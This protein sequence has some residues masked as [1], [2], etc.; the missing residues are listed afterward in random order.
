M[1]SKCSFLKIA[2]KDILTVILIIVGDFSLNGKELMK[3]KF[4]YLFHSF[5][6]HKFNYQKKFKVKDVAYKMDVDPSEFYKI[7]RQEK[8]FPMDWLL[9]FIKATDFDYL[10][11][12]ANECGF[13]LI[14]DIKNDKLKMV[15]TEIAKMLYLVGSL[16][17][18]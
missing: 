15:L 2:L 11:F 7:L 4:G 18:E 12:L 17:D 3:R 9:P 10:E 1:A 14:P 8:E 5:L 16:E 6:V 13:K